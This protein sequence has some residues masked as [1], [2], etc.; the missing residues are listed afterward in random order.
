MP[1]LNGW[2]AHSSSSSS[3]ASNEIKYSACGGACYDD[4]NDL[5][6]LDYIFLCVTSFFFFPFFLLLSLYQTT[7]DFQ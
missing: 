2:Q 5:P 3:V 6:F 1:L 4:D 7:R